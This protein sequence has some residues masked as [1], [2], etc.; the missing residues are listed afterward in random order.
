M[1]RTRLCLTIVALIGLFFVARLPFGNR[2]IY[3]PD[4]SGIAR[5]TNISVPALQSP[6][7]TY[8]KYGHE[9]E[10]IWNNSRVLGEQVNPQAD[11]T[12]LRIRVLAIPGLHYPVRIKEAIERR[13]NNVE[14][15]VKSRTE[16]AAEHILAR[17]KKG[18]VASEIETALKPYGVRMHGG[19][20]GSLLQIEL[21]DSNPMAVDEILT[22]VQG[23]P[24]LFE[25]AEPD[26]LVSV[27]NNE[28]NDPAYTSGKLWGLHNLTEFGG[29]PEADIDADGAWER[30][31]DASSVIVAVI[32][33]GIR[34]THED[35][36]A[37]IWTNSGEVP[38][39]G[40]DNDGNGIV[41]DVHG[42]NAINNNGDPND[43]HGHGTHVAGTI[44]ARG[45]NGIGS[46]GVAWSIQLMAVKFL[47]AEGIGFT[48]DAIKGIDYARKMGASVFNNS[49]AGGAYSQSLSE[50][51]ERARS[52]G[53][54]FVAAAGNNGSS[55]DAMPQYPAAFTHDNIVS[56]AASTITDELSSFSNYG[57]R[58]VDIAAPG[59]GIYSTYNASDSAYETF[60]GTSMAAP[61]VSG[62]LAMLKA[63]FPGA[64]YRELIDRLLSTADHPGA[65]ALLMRSQGRLNLARAL[66]ATAVIDL[67]SITRSPEATSVLAG[68]TATFIVAAEGGEPLTYQ[69][70]RNGFGIPGETNTI[71]KLMNVSASDRA[72][73][74]VLVTNPAG[75]RLSEDAML[76]VSE[77]VKI[78]TQPKSASLTVDATFMVSVEAAG[79]GPISYQWQKDGSNI[80]GAV[81]REFAIYGVNIS[82]AGGYSVAV[83]N[84][85][86]GAVSSVAELEVIAPPQMTISPEDKVGVVGES[87]TFTSLAEGAALKYQWYKDGVPLP[88]AENPT[89]TLT[90]LSQSDVGSYSARASNVA[91]EVW[92]ESAVL[93]LKNSAETK[94]Y[95]Q[96][97]IQ[98]ENHM[99]IAGDGLSFIGEAT[100]SDV[101]YQ[102]RKNGATIPGATGSI[103]SFNSV[104]TADAGVYTLI[105]ANAEGLGASRAAKLIIVETP[106]VTKQPRSVSGAPGATIALETEAVSTGP[107]YYQW[108]KDGQAISGATKPRLIIS[109]LS[110]SDTGTYALVVSNLAGSVRTVAATVSLI[111][112]PATSWTQIAPTL[113]EQHQ[114]CVVGAPDGVYIGGQDGVYSF[115]ADGG[116]SWERRRPVKPANSISTIAYG[117]GRYV[118]LGSELIN[119][120]YTPFGLTSADGITWLR[121]G[122]APLAS[123]PVTDLHFDGSNFY[124][125][126]E[127]INFASSTN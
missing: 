126:A 80:P 2:K 77:P 23:L 91:G 5:A 83:S 111:A 120:R 97:Q 104:S 32:D 82:D 27:E 99:A 115:S 65:F 20:D 81:S 62:A 33:T 60:S 40:I 63:E 13:P 29:P 79:D 50:A 71:L 105:A 25:Y 30:R 118:A 38:G 28:P 108:E 35:L 54:L 17:A 66:S 11:G 21:R 72:R 119:S 127:G 74:S 10:R 95:P 57:L 4:Q 18:I 88:G 41:D 85:A 51:I 8:R 43:D 90:V 100:P 98:P 45:D 113:S 47:S 52:A 112:T 26:Y 68:E 102:W 44:G 53:I 76:A 86:S 31:T 7:S 59:S 114:F 64:T 9:R 49:W 109:Y 103:L 116:I 122:S 96:F 14:P 117:N 61:H 55:S 67:P 19:M 106:H 89:L 84:S 3:L 6:R 24:E 78:V 16:M 69:W 125:V 36:A 42:Y 123:Y 56:V 87:A 107:L 1:K 48:S 34:Y 15:L 75:L 121:S 39:D 124:M 94:Q 58:S 37:N 110:R 70:R 46:V 92:S 73:Y 101:S 93:I 22:V 12:D